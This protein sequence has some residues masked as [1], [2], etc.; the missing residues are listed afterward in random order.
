MHIILKK[1]RVSL[2]LVHIII[3]SLYNSKFPAKLKVAKLIP[4]FKTTNNTLQ[5]TIDHL[6][7]VNFSKFFKSKL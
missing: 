7:I 1:L 3:F 5:L 2:S 6:F 4:V